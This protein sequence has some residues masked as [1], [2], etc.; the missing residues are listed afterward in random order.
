M[1]AALMR[2]STSSGPGSGRATSV[3]CS[4]SGAPSALRITAFMRGMPC[5][6]SLAPREGGS[7]GLVL[8]MGFDQRYDRFHL[9][10]LGLGGS[11]REHRQPLGGLHGSRGVAGN[12]C[13]PFLRLGRDVVDDSVDQA[14]A[15]RFLG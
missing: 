12:G 14:P 7:A 2:T 13:C 4:T 1:P 8:V 15:Q 5:S 11:A 6:L 9:G 10:A 3:T